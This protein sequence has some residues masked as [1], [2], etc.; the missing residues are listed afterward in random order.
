MDENPYGA[1]DIGGSPS[2]SPSPLLPSAAESGIQTSRQVAPGNGCGEPGGCGGGRGDHVHNVHKYCGC[3]CPGTT[4]SW[5]M[6]LW[7][8][9]SCQQAYRGC[10]EKV[11]NFTSMSS[12]HSAKDT[13]NSTGPGLVGDS[14][15]SGQVACII[16]STRD[17][18]ERG[19]C[20]SRRLSG[21]SAVLSK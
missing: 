19:Y 7:L 6:Q 14:S 20:L 10:N 8:L 12:L 17:K 13:N 2:H 9:R 1:P 21:T 15:P 4:L 16:R 3:N 18:V 11:S 5:H